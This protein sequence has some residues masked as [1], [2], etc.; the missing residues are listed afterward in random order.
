MPA[1]TAKSPVAKTTAKSGR[2][3]RGR[4]IAPEETRRDQIIDAALAVFA[5]EGFHKATI[6]AIGAEA[7]LKSP[8]LIY[9]Y[10]TDK[11]EL[12]E[13]VAVERAP[14][15]RA[16]P[17]LMGLVDEPPEVVLPMVAKA[18]LSLLDMPEG[19][20]IFRLFIGEMARQPDLAEHFSREALMKMKDFLDAYL[21]RQIELGRLRPH[22]TG[23]GA[24]SLVGQLMLYLMTNAMLPTMAEGLPDAGTYA[25]HAVD[26]FLHG[27]STE[28]PTGTSRA[29]TSKKRK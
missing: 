24:A 10:F 22:N 2:A 16:V 14:M 7:G 8:A 28:K 20:S 25:D 13:T 9:W 4:G 29:G 26:V 5:R 15:L 19:P 27:L 12:F 23:A 3:T 21:Q 1:S 18:Y 6:K 11:R 17:D